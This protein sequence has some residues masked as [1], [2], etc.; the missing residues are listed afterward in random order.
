M[1]AARPV[2]VLIVSGAGTARLRLTVA[3]G[4][5]CAGLVATVVG[6]LA[7]MLMMTDYVALKRQR[8]DVVAFKQEIGEQRRF[9]DVVHQR[10]SEIQSEV[11]TWQELHT[12]IVKPENPRA[13]ASREADRPDTLVLPSPEIKSEPATLA[14]ELDRL[15]ASVR[16]EGQKLRALE[17]F[18][19]R[20]G[21]VLAVL[22]SGWPL[23]GSVTSEFGRRRS[24]LSGAPEFHGGI[25]IAAVGGTPI[26][27][28]ASGVVIF[29]GNTTD[30][31]TT[32][33]LDHGEDV[34]SLFG[35]LQKVEVTEG[36]RVARGQRVALSGNT[37]KSTGPHLHYQ[38]MVNGQPVNPRSLLEQ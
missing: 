5:V 9:I 37:G 22:P 19:A 36:Q 2:N 14:S 3:Y 8:W 20:A 16:E 18:M 13:A 30:H 29:A 24:P 6:V 27:A 34:K 35:H 12:R 10:M 38:V 21:R 7:L 31:G 28:P 23:R 25:D 33:I 17:R 4:A 26:K 32:L 11:A 1:K 15:V